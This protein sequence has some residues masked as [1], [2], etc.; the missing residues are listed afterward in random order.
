LGYRIFRSSE[1]GEPF[2]SISDFPIVGGQYVDVGIKDD[3]RYF[4]YI[5][6]VEIETSLDRATQELIDEVIGPSGE[7]VKVKTSKI[8]TESDKVKN[9][10]LMQIG[11]DTMMVNEH[12]QEIDPGR[13]TTPIILNGRTVVQIRAIVEAM[14]GTVGWDDE[15]KQIILEAYNHRIL[16]T[17][18]DNAIIVDGV[19]KEIDVPPTVINDRTMVPIR[20]VAENIGCHI[21]WIG[22]SQEIIIVYY[23]AAK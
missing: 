11:K 6:A 17:P 22:S 21:Q 16:M 19:K 15:T 7:I 18:D 4:Y 3:I 20:F 9:F 10:I 23:G 5:C 2:A 14:G 8:V 1:T 12:A 13:G